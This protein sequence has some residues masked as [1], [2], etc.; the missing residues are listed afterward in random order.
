MNTIRAIGCCLF[1]L[2][3]IVGSAQDLKKG[4]INVLSEEQIQSLVDCLSKDKQLLIERKRQEYLTK[5]ARTEQ[6]LYSP[7][8]SM[9]ISL[10]ETFTQDTT[11]EKGGRERIIHDRAALYVKIVPLVVRA[12]SLLNQKYD[13]AAIK[14]VS[15]TLRPYLSNELL[16]REQLRELQKQVAILDS[17]KNENAKFKAVFDLDKGVLDSYAR[18][19]MIGTPASS[20]VEAFVQ[21]KLIPYLEQQTVFFAFKHTEVPYL[22]KLYKQMA[23]ELEVIRQSDETSLEQI[24]LFLGH[25]NDL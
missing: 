13:A 21:G 6:Y 14:S 16:T 23:K 22:E 8:R 10:L 1:L 7:L 3:S 15:D 18:L 19:K 2:I 24:E 12:D 11:W 5:L 20:L 25:K 17:Y 4:G 9:Q